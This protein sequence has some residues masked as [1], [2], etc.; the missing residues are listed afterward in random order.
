MWVSHKVEEIVGVIVLVAG[1]PPNR[2]QQ[3][4]PLLPI[5]SLHNKTIPLSLME[6]LVTVH[7]NNRQVR[8]VSLLQH[9]QQQQK[10]QLIAQIVDLLLQIAIPQVHR[11]QRTHRLQIVEV[12]LVIQQIQPAEMLKERML[13]LR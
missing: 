2:M 9:P 1:I 4:M 3:V 11:P 13:I 5:R 8:V 12:H 7:S 6:H 10:Q